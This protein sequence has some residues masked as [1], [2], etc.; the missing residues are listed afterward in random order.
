MKIIKQGVDP[1]TVP[2][3]GTCMNCRTQV[4]FLKSE[5]T[6]HRAGLDQR[7]SEHWSVPCPVCK[8]SINGFG[9][10]RSYYGGLG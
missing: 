1:D 7:D 2:M 9:K 6:H 5:A 3:L 8:Q 10:S 4:E